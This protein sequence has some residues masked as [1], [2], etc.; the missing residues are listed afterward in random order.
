MTNPPILNFRRNNLAGFTL[1][2]ILLTISLSAL[3]LGVMA[4]LVLSFS[5]QNDLDLAAA[6]VAQSLRRAQSLSFSQNKDSAWGVNIQSQD[7]ILFTGESFGTRDQD[8]D[9]VF[10]LPAAL[11][12]VGPTEIVFTKLYGLPQTVGIISLSNNFNQS[13]TVTVNGEG[14]VEY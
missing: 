12:L 4:P 13:R 6:V 8:F 10:H 2:E 3:A 5:A 9:E 14:A 11:T 1:I 7:I